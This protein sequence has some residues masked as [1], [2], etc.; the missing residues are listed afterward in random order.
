MRRIIANEVRNGER[1]AIGTW[2][3]MRAQRINEM[4]GHGDDPLAARLLLS[5]PFGIPKLEK[6]STKEIFVTDVGRFDAR[7]SHVIATHEELHV[8]G[9]PRASGTLPPSTTL[10]L[11]YLKE[12]SASPAAQLLLR[13]E[14]EDEIDPEQLDSP[15]TKSRLASLGISDPNVTSPGLLR[16]ALHWF[17]LSSSHEEK[18]DEAEAA[19]AIQATVRYGTVTP[20]PSTE[21]RASTR[22]AT[23]T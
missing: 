8:P 17:G 11:P 20:T 9:A 14:E 5:S 3:M 4:A 18:E 19:D 23:H 16:R 15:I 2:D 22:N 1:E 21:H 12:A 13:A 10:A 7:S 6:A